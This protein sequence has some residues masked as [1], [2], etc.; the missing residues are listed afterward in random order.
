MEAWIPLATVGGCFIILEGRFRVPAILLERNERK[1]V[2][3][4]REGEQFFYFETE[5]I[6][7]HGR[8]W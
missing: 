6:S 8:R 7:V 1:M 2:R 4:F 5:T 3:T